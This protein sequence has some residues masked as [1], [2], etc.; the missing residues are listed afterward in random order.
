VNATPVLE[1][2]WAGLRRNLTMTIAVILTVGVSLALLGVGILLGRQVGVMKDYWYN[3][4]EV[5][6]Y[7]NQNVTADQRDL[8]ASDLNND[9]LVQKVFYESQQQAYQRFKQQFK[10]SPDLVKEVTPAELPESFRVK[11]K[12]PQQYEIIAATYSG[13]AGVSEVQDQREL[14]KGFFKGLKYMQYTALSIGLAQA[15]AALLLVSITIRTAA[16]NRRRETGIMRLVGAT[17]LYIQLPFVLEGALAGLVG[18]LVAVGGLVAFKVYVVDHRL[19]KS[20]HAFPF[21]GWNAVSYAM[22]LVVVCGVALPTLAS[23][24][25][26]RKHLR[27]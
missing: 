15:V 17:K 27:V 12:N 9:P 7:L 23:L 26:L 21:V 18:S 6:I 24:V 2:T 13:R 10:N 22:V 4:V 14:L 25:T 16:F 19:A 11:L 20:I 3:K 1:E 8:L 5:S